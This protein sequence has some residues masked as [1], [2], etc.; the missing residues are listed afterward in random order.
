M[1]LYNRIATV[2]IGP[3]GQAAI[4][5]EGLRV[6]FD[7]KKTLSSEPNTGTVT[8]TNLSENSRERIREIDTAVVVSAG[9]R[10]QHGAELLASG[11]VVNVRHAKEPPDIHTII[12]FA[13]GQKELRTVAAVSYAENTTVS[14]AIQDIAGRL[15]LPEKTNLLTLAAGK[16]KLETG[17]SF[18]GPLRE[19]LDKLT[20]TAGLDWSIQNQELKFTVV[21]GDDSTS[22]IPLSPASGLVGFPQRLYA[23]KTKEGK[24]RKG[25]FDGWRIESLLQP[26]AEPGGL[27]TVE[28][29]DITKA[30]FKIVNV[31]HKGDTH[32]SDWTTT[33]EIRQ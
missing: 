16:E 6:D 20:K 24:V 1:G 29:F 32:G 15:G 17:F 13:D 12:D 7:V 10:D 19:A 25:T 3:V 27:V 9:Y 30:E 4:L 14:Q 23:K 2:A 21:D 5:V 26:K 18:I 28:A 8:V 22:P 33:M 31:T 11:N